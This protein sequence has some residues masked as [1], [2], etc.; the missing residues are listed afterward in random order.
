MQTIKMISLIVPFNDSE[1][2]LKKLL[3]EIS[4]NTIL[5]AELIIVNASKTTL[6]VELFNSINL[7]SKVSIKVINYQNFK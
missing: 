1:E 5:P 6:D 2:N 3:N 7:N 4:K